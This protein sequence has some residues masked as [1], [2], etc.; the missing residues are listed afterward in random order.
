MAREIE[1]LKHQL[2]RLKSQN[3]GSLSQRIEREIGQLEFEARRARGRPRATE[4]FPSLTVVKHLRRA[5]RSTHSWPF[6]IS[7]AIALAGR[8]SEALPLLEEGGHQA[9]SMN[10]HGTLPIWLTDLGDA[11]LRAGRIDDAERNAVRALESARALEECG[12]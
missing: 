9:I 8:I 12:H 4:Q 1:K 6:K 3:Y 5:S 2:A 11:Y 7:C 10:L